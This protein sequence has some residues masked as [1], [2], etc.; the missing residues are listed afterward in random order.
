MVFVVLLRGIH[1]R[2]DFDTIMD[3]TKFKTQASW[4]KD[5]MKDVETKVKSAF[6]RQFNKSGL[7]VK[8]TI[9]VEDAKK[10]KGGKKAVAVEPADPEIGGEVAEVWTRN[11][12]TV[13]LPCL[14]ACMLPVFSS[15]PCDTLST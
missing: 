9:M 1:C 7:P 14:L 8:T 3:I 15:L 11:R 6:T 5:P 10:T 12:T 4:G 13:S 2:D